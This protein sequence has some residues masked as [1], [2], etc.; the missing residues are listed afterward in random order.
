LGLAT[1]G[2][3][4]ARLLDL[5]ERG[6]V[7]EARRGRRTLL[8]VDEAQTLGVSALEELRMLSNFT[9]Q[10]R[11]LIQIVLTGQPEF[12][13]KLVSGGPLEQLRQRVIATHHLEPMEG[14]EVE[15]YVVHRLSVA[16]WQGRPAFAPDAWSALY[17]HSGGIPRRLNQLMT[18]LLLH[19][20][21]EGLDRVE[22]GAVDQV[23]ADLDA[24]QARPPVAAEAAAYRPAEPVR[25][26]ALERRVATLEARL[27]EQEQAVRRVLTL[28]VEWVEN[29]Q[30]A[31]GYTNAA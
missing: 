6:L 10:G 13:D 31:P 17:R 1:D 23:V 26:L 11:A 22:G 25:D 20:A 30:Q 27:Q 28:L 5:V 15:G 7:D 16:G 24:D 21:V 19:A 9:D 18:R 29:G 4:K 8:V 3:D 14:N 12:R 2:L